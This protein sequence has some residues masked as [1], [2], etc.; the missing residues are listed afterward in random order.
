MSTPPYFVMIRVTSGAEQ[1]KVKLVSTE[2]MKNPLK[3]KTFQPSTKY[4][5][6]YPSKPGEFYKAS[7]LVIEGKSRVSF[8][9]EYDTEK[10]AQEAFVAEHPR[11]I[12]RQP[13]TLLH[14]ETEQEDTDSGLTNEKNSSSK[15][16]PASF[17]QKENHAKIQDPIGIQDDCDLICDNDEKILDVV[18][19]RKDIERSG[20]EIQEEKKKHEI[21]SQSLKSDEKKRPN[22]SKFKV[23]ATITSNVKVHDETACIEKMK[24]KDNEIKEL[25]KQV[26]KLKK[27]VENQKQTKREIQ[28]KYSDLKEKKEDVENLNIKLQK[29]ILERFEEEKLVADNLEK[30]GPCPSL[31]QQFVP[32]GTV[33]KIDRMIHVGTNRWFSLDSYTEAKGSATD[34]SEVVGNLLTKIFSVEELK[35]GTRTG[36]PSNAVIGRYRELLKSN[37]D[38][39]AAYKRAK[40]DSVKTLDQSRMNDC[41]ELYKYWLREKGHD[42]PALIGKFGEYVTKKI[43]NVKKGKQCPKT[44]KCTKKDTEADDRTENLQLEPIII[45]EEREVSDEHSSEQVDNGVE[46]VIAESSLPGTSSNFCTQESG[47]LHSQVSKTNEDDLP[48]ED[49]SPLNNNESFDDITSNQET[50]SL[51][52]Q[53]QYGIY[54]Q[55]SDDLSAKTESEDEE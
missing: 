50:P 38:E 29:K 26:E 42:D 24:Q 15:S 21:K 7:I 52:K 8:T 48:A 54:D 19:K 23:R 1:G 41:F 9:A 22:A 28:K 36:K 16:K 6:K 46:S 20:N 45:L 14:T 37:I 5:F 13:S 10:A 31:E 4:F 53:D 25:K 11:R 17:I 51:F 33:R 47:E 55:D 32:I 30:A 49:M 44:D 12:R 18:P 39:A 34:P 27:E 2:E 40:I 3:T 35:E 43:A